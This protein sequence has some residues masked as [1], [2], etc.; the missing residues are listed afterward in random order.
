MTRG[1]DE[2]ASAAAAGAAGAATFAGA[3]RELALFLLL[4]FLTEAFFTAL[5]VL[6]VAAAL[7]G[8]VALPCPAA[9]LIMAQRAF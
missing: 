7:A 4:A 2:E 5:R 9:F 1:Y 3:R 8:T 6:G